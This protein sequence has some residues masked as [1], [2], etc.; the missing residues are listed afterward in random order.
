MCNCKKRDMQLYQEL[1]QAMDQIMREHKAYKRQCKEIVNAINELSEQ[2]E[3]HEAILEE[4]H[5]DLDQ[6]EHNH[7][8]LD[9]QRHNR[10]KLD[11]EE[12]HNHSKRDQQK[13]NRF[14]QDK[15]K[16]NTKESQRCKRCKRCEQCGR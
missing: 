16:G 11:Q 10:S 7:S 13:H 1:A 2:V 3:E 9:Q 15:H 12:K 6:E 4:M 14:K 8:K 5:N